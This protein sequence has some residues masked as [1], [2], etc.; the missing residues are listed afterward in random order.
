MMSGKVYFE[1]LVVLPV[2]IRK[3][4]V[5]CKMAEARG[6]RAFVDMSAP[7]ELKVCVG[8]PEVRNVAAGQLRWLADEI[9]KAVKGD[10][11]VKYSMIDIPLLPGPVCEQVAYA[12]EKKPVQAELPI[13]GPL[14]PQPSGY[15]YEISFYAS[16]KAD[17]PAGWY[18]RFLRLKD[19]SVKTVKVDSGIDW[20]HAS[21][22]AQAQY[23]VAIQAVRDLRERIEAAGKSAQSFALVLR[24]V[25]RT[26]IEQCR[27]TWTVER[28]ELVPWRD[29]LLEEAYKFGHVRFVANGEKIAGIGSA[30]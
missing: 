22:D 5:I 24:S 19:G 18:R 25:Q 8:G 26:A 14:L 10:V 4:D 6:F 11:E 16:V 21:S 13:G 15:E 2:A 23:A 9:A 1:G 17:G 28:G 27:G 20:G 30:A 7:H 3:P 12:P 29:E